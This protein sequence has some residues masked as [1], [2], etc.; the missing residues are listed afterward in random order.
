[1]EHEMKDKC[2]KSISN[3]HH[4][5]DKYLTVLTENGFKKYGVCDFC[6]LVDDT[7]EFQIDEKIYNK[8]KLTTGIIK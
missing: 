7:K 2:E 3:N 5:V 8:I 4:F 6:H 1:M